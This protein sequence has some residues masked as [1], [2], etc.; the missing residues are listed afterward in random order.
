MRSLTR[1]PFALLALAFCCL[2]STE[3]KA[4]PL[5]IDS[6]FIFNQ[7]LGSSFST[8]NFSG[9]AISVNANAR[10]TLIFIRACS[11]CTSVTPITLTPMASFV[12][13]GGTVVLNGTTYSSIFTPGILEISGPSFTLPVTT[14]D[15][16]LSITVPFQMTGELSGDTFNPFIGT[17]T[18]IVFT[19]TLIGQGFVTFQYSVT[20]SNG[21]TYYSYLN[22]TYN[23]QPA[24][25]PEPVTILLLGTGLAGVAARVRKR[26]K[27]S[28]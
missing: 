3:A 11:P 25:V 20:H 6:G 26:G 22:S 2:I 5:V 19:T 14:S 23:F 15:P 18:N 8:F 28:N 16:I 7:G 1:L 24:P 9:P 4:D 17:Q 10:D 13:G 27:A 12:G 21:F